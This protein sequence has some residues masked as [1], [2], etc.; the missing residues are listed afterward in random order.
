M[1]YFF[2]AEKGKKDLFMPCIL[3][4]HVQIG[5]STGRAKKLRGGVAEAFPFIANSEVRV[6]HCMLSQ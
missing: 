3:L 4:L 6:L 5:Y 2:Q 1:K